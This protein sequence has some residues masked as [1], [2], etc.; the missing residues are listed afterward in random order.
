MKL[1][2]IKELL[3]CEVLYGQDVI[4]DI[5]ISTCLC[6]D[7]MSD[8]LAFA[9]PWAL[10][11]TG[12]TNSQSVRTANI[13]DAAAVVYIRGKRPDKQTLDLAEEMRIPLLATDMGMFDACGKLF[14][15]GLRGIC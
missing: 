4:D 8:V 5:E 11:L 3:D 9:E 6:S 1:S 2:E 14:E 7:M 10:L 12:L 13:A 15:G